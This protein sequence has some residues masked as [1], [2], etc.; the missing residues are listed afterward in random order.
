MQGKTKIQATHQ[1]QQG[2]KAWIQCLP[3]PLGQA[4]AHDRKRQ[5]LESKNKHNCD[6][7]ANHH[8]HP[9]VGLI[10]LISKGLETTDTEGVDHF[11]KR[12]RKHGHRSTSE[13]TCDQADN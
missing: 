2:N 1:L 3:N 11:G 12:K 4:S 13:Q 6:A 10:L 9:Q 5:W 7:H 8:K